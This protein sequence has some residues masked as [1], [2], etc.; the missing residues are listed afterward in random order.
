MSKQR[1]ESKNPKKVM[2]WILGPQMKRKTPSVTRTCNSEGPCK[3]PSVTRTVQM[4]KKM[5]SVTRTCNNEEENT[6]CDK[7]VQQ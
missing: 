4:K 7:D 3:M 5:L 6:E 2:L 1:N